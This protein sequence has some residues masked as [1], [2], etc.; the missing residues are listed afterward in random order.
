MQ[1]KQLYAA[2][3]VI[4]TIQ[5]QSN[6]EKLNLKDE[7]KVKAATALGIVHIICGFVAFLA[8]M[9]GM[10]AHD[11]SFLPPNPLGITAVFFFATGGVAIG[12]ARSRNKHT[13]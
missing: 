2:H 4:Y 8:E 7:N 13:F 5:A 11:F 3:Q 10:F 6:D 1:Q 9:T 12:G